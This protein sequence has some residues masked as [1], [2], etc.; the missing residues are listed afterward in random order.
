MS[1]IFNPVNRKRNLLFSLGALLSVF[2]LI[3]LNGYSS[4]SD[5]ETMG[6]YPNDV[7]LTSK[8]AISKL[9][10]LDI[11]NED[12]L[13]E[14]NQIVS[15]SI[16]HYMSGDIYSIS[17]SIK[18]MKNNLWIA[19][20]NNYIIWTASFFYPKFRKFHLF[21][22]KSI[23]NR[24]IGDCSQQAIALQ[25][26][27][28]KSGVNAYIFGLDGH[29]VVYVNDQKWGELVLDPDIGVYLPYTKDE[30]QS[31]PSL[32]EPYY[33][34]KGISESTIKKYVALFARSN[35]EFDP[36]YSR[37]SE[38]VY[39]YRP[40][41]FL[42]WKISEIIKWIIPICLIFPLIHNRFLKRD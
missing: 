27:L 9:N 21:N 20:T 4:P 8:E 15:S 28:R 25:D 18:M 19:P 33:R 12:F 36:P 2:N 5:I 26:F 40:K 41:L 3:S 32:I 23:I 13:R 11:E 39:K 30:I 17:D 42:F 6:V 37:L 29:V 16:A 24:G 34:D 14:A 31:N 35:Q 38:S 7:T 22:Y 1:N 10:S